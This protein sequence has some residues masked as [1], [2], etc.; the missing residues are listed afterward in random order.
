MR[1]G[2]KFVIN[3][4]WTNFEILRM[5]PASYSWGTTVAQIQFQPQI[6]INASNSILQII[7]CHIFLVLLSD[8]YQVPKLGEVKD[9]QYL[10]FLM[11]F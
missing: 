11:Y 8:L 2:Y 3:I 4:K 10:I 7:F 1:D 9:K 6:N 5:H